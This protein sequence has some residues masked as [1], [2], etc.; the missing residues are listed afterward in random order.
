MKIKQRKIAGG[1]ELVKWLE[2][3]R[4]VETAGDNPAGMPTVVMRKD[5]KS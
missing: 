4:A 3:A 1:N 2:L 5:V